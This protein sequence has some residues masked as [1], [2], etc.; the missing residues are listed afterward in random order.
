MFP[1]TGSIPT[2]SF[3]YTYTLCPIAYPSVSPKNLNR[4][5][6]IPQP[7]SSQLSPP[8]VVLYVSPVHP[9]IHPVVLFT[10]PI[11]SWSYPFTKL[12][13]TQFVPPL[14]VFKKIVVPPFSLS[15]ETYPVSAD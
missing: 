12:F 13:S 1:E 3:E 5:T 14:V 4:F 11:P 15:T 2:R 9:P 8:L 7:A 10:N 6:F